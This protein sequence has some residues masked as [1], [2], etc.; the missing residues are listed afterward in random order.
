VLRFR[1]SI[2]ASDV[3]SRRNG[4]RKSVGS[5]V[6]KIVFSLNGVLKSSHLGFRR[7]V[8]QD[9]QVIAEFYDPTVSPPKRLPSRLNRNLASDDPA[10]L[11][12]FNVGAIFTMLISL[13]YFLGANCGCFDATA[14]SRTDAR[15]AYRID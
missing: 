4:E 7:F 6:A 3:G 10:A 2:C 8:R 14:P 11:Q 9:K 1:R 13:I 5:K 12:R 15:A